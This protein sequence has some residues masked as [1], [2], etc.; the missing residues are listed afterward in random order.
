MEVSHQQYPFQISLIFKS[1]L[2]VGNTKSQKI[3][4]LPEKNC[5]YVFIYNLAKS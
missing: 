2:I 4:A 3:V 1:D 5:S